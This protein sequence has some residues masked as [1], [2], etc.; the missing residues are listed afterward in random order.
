MVEKIIIGKDRDDLLKYGHKGTVLIGKHI[1]GKGEEAHLTNPVMMDVS[2][3]HVVLICGK[4]GTGKCVHGDT[5]I[6]L[7]DGSLVPISELMQDKEAVYSLDDSLKIVETER[8]EFF[9]REVETLLKIRLRSGKEIKLTPEHPLLTLEGWKPAIELNI[10]S[11]IATPRRLAFFGNKSIPENEVK[12][13]AYLIAEGHL[14][15][16]FIL[17]SNTDPIITEDFIDSVKKF[18]PSLRII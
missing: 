9:Q 12:L 5:L 10:G 4:R 13:L 15:N 14:G 1:V 7:A 2:R 8:T 11:R 3:P 6:P 18:D 17:F 16:N